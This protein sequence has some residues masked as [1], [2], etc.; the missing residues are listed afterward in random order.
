MVVPMSADS[1]TARWFPPSRTGPPAAKLMFCFPHAGGGTSAFQLWQALL[2]PSVEV[3]PVRLP[4]REIR[5][6]E[7]VARSVRELSDA[8]VRPVAEYAAGRPFV[9]LGHSMGALIAYELSHGLQAMSVPQDALI[10]SGCSAPHAP[11]RRIFP[12]A[13]P[14]NE[15]SDEELRKYIRSLSKTPDEL[16]MDPGMAEILLPIV[17]KDFMICD[18]YEWAERARL[19]IPILVLG[20]TDDRI[21]PPGDLD[22]WADLTSAKTQVRTFAGGHFYFDDQLPD[23][24][25]CISATMDMLSSLW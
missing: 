16:L 12:S 21:A 25:A 11:R 18:T 2:G 24:L 4:G 14:V 10:V 20:G 17:R 7:P 23:V 15:V 9:L 19:S 1:A 6:N 3:I 8:L 5:F 22:R 13:K